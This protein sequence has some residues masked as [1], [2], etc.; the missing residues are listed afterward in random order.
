MVDMFGFHSTG[1]WPL[2]ERACSR[3]LEKTR[4]DIACVYSRLS[5]RC[6]DF[7]FSHLLPPFIS[8]RSGWEKLI[9]YQANSFRD[10]FGWENFG[11]Y[12]IGSLI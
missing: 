2:N 11:K 3:Q 5:S 6:S 1:V 7:S 9:K 10:F 8:Y 4:K 12:F